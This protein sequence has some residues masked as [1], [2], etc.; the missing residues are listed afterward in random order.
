[1]FFGYKKYAKIGGL[2]LKTV[3]SLL[4]GFKHHGITRIRQP[5]DTFNNKL[6]TYEI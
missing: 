3:K 6:H 2:N 4:K 5:Y 1:M